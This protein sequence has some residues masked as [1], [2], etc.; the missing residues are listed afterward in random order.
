MRG[1]CSK[2][3]ASAYPA[4]YIRYFA[5]HATKIRTNYN[6]FQHQS[7][8]ARCLKFLLQN[9]K[10]GGITMKRKKL[11]VLAF[12]TVCALSFAGEASARG[13]AGAGG[14]QGAGMGLQ[15][16]DG[17]CIRNS[18]ATQT[19]TQTRQRLQDGSGTNSGTSRQGPGQGQMRQLGPGD[20]TGNATRPM[21]GTGYGSPAK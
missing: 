19:Q 1:R 14:G 17:S 18:T 10:K 7:C 16:R 12:L 20:G 2:F 5:I 6:K 11:A 13:G 8:Q 9:D 21:D 15:K 4:P 3:T